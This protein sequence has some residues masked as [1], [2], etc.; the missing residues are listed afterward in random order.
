MFRTGFTW[1]SVLLLFPLSITFSI[2][3]HG[4]LF[5]FMFPP[6]NLENVQVPTFEAI[7]AYILFFWELP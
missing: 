2:F 5:Y 3:M 7:L 6:Y 4:F 1:V